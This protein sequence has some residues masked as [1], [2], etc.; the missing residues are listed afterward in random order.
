MSYD[1][2]TMSVYSPRFVDILQVLHII[3]KGEVQ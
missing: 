1:K 2:G 3:F